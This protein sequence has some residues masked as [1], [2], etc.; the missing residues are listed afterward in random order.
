[1]TRQVHF[2]SIRDLKS[3]LQARPKI[4]GLIVS[5]ST[6]RLGACGGQISPGSTRRLEGLRKTL[7]PLLRK[8]IPSWARE[9]SL[10]EWI[11]TR[12]DRLE[13]RRLIGFKHY[14][15]HWSDSPA[16]HPQMSELNEDKSAG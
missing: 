13:P 6:Q 9:E 10:A 12:S 15:Q 8:A 7:G 14:P 4:F 2:Q 1:M 16:Q 3:K 11:D 5:K